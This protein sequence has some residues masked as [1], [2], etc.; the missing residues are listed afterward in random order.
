VVQAPA[1][2]E[3]SSPVEDTF[4]DFMDN[5]VKSDDE[6]MVDDQIS[7]TQVETSYDA[8]DGVLDDSRKGEESNGIQ[9]WESSLEEESQAKSVWLDEHGDEH[10]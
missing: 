6:Q 10:P 3:P 9:S 7:D 1:E 2:S 8:H 5:V 4:G